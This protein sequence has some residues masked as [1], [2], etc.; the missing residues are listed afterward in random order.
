MRRAPGLGL[1]VQIFIVYGLRESHV[2]GELDLK[3]KSNCPLAH[4]TST[5]DKG[6]EAGP[7]YSVKCIHHFVNKMYCFPAFCA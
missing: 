3:F 5:N 6:G 1:E 4:I 7:N 2:G